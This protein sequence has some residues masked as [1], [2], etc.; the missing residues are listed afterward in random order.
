MTVEM[1]S[2]GINTIGDAPWGSHI[3]QFHQT[4]DDLIDILAPYLKAGL[5][6]NEFCMWITSEPLG[7]GDARKSLGKEVGNLDNYISEGQIEILDSSEWY[8]KGGKF[9]SDRVLQGWVE[10]ERQAL[11]LGFDGIRVSGNMSWLQRDQWRAFA[12]YEVD[13]EKVIGKHR[14]IALCSYPLDKCVPSDVIDVLK[15]HNF[16]VYRYEG[17]WEIIETG[18]FRRKYLDAI[19]SKGVGFFIILDNS[20]RMHYV[21]P[22][23]KQLLGYTAEELFAGELR[24]HVHPDDLKTLDK[25]LTMVMRY[26]G[27][28]LSGDLRIRRKNG[29]WRIFEFS[30]QNLLYDPDIKGIVNTFYDV[31]Q[32]KQ[33][34]TD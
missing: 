4:K 17:K 27:R 24:D 34:R 3:S 7:V 5:S 12:E 29:A 21:S 14:M 6:N 30:S 28:T 25:I 32:R 26:P 20:L 15:N 9:E 18:Q 19:L 33:K 11:G 13:I 22:S 8:T 10:K 16:N 31:T 2:T 1:R 23:V